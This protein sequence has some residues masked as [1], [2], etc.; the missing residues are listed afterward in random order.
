MLVILHLEQE[1]EKFN[2]PFKFNSIWL[3]EP[4]FVDLVRTTQNRLLDIE[5]INPMDS[6][7]QKLK[8]LKSMVIKWERNKK[9]LA[10]E[11]LIQLETYLDILYFDFPRGFVKDDEKVLVLEKEKRKSFLRK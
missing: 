1:K 9:H 10:K 3:D 4:D 7:V 6:L 8:L 5:D 11:E 2:Y